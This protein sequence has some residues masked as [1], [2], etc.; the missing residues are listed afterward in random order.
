MITFKIS[1]EPVQQFAT[2]LNDRRVTLL[3]RYSVTTDRWSLDLS[4]DDLPVL[5]GRRIVTGIDLLE[6][7]DFGIGMLVAAPI[8]AGAKPTREDLPNGNVKLF[9]LLPEELSA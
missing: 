8:K 2:I 9:H 7:F 3:L 1:T 4:I 6:P 5:V